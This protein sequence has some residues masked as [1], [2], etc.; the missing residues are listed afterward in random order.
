MAPAVV[1]GLG[2]EGKKGATLAGTHVPRLF[3]HLLA[4]RVVHR[5]PHCF[6]GLDR[7]QIRSFRIGC[8]PQYTRGYVG[9]YGREGDGGVLRVT[10][11]GS[12]SVQLSRGED[13]GDGGVLGVQRVRERGEKLK[14]KGAGRDG[15]RERETTT[16][17]KIFTAAAGAGP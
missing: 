15:E 8:L 10:R 17:N 6:W 2:V 11:K 12:E 1:R 9:G 16:W 13:G 7:I 5:C 14:G 3:D 4:S